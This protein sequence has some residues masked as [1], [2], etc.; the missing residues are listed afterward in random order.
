MDRPY[1]LRLPHD[2]EQF[3]KDFLPFE[4]RFVRRDGIHLFGLRYWDDVLSPWAG[5]G[6]RVR[7][8]Y[9]PRDLSRVQ[10]EGAENFVETVHFADLRR[11]RITLGE[12]RL[13]MAALRAR[14]V[15]AV[16]EDLI[17]STIAEQRRLLAD[18]VE[19]TRT[20]RRTAERNERALSAGRDRITLPEYEPT[21]EVFDDLPPLSVEEWS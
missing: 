8:R 13:A 1:P 12:H 2:P 16:N 3:L 4:E 10:V 17:F 9:D 21:P 7:V 20:V 18:A 11:P 14:G 6:Q 15:Q 5:R 19:K